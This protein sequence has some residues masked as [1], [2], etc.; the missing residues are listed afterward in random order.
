MPQE[1]EHRVLASEVR[2]GDVLVYDGERFVVEDVDRKTK[3][4]YFTVR[5]DASPTNEYPPLLER[6][7]RGHNESVTVVRSEPTEAEARDRDRRH[8]VAWLEQRLEAFAPTLE[9][10]LTKLAAAAARYPLAPEILDW[11][12]LAGL[13]EYQAER[14][15]W[16]EL[17]RVAD[18]IGGPPSEDSRLSRVLR[19]DALT[20]L[21]YLRWVELRNERRFGRE[22]RSP[23]SRSTSAASNLLEDLKV[24]G[25]DRFW[26]NLWYVE[27]SV[28]A[29]EVELV[30]AA[31]AEAEAEA[32]EKKADER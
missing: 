13:L 22:P 2:A 15:P 16:L 10:E 5:I 4:A 12:K 20:A 31:F 9:G 1:V 32:E 19:G 17:R 18:A 3:Y 25:A 29:A 23:L 21:A 28:L 26:A 6:K 7:K 30:A 11:S 27:P 14:A 8:A 24:W